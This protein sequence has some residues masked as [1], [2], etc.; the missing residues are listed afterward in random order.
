MHIQLFYVQLK[1]PLAS[2]FVRRPEP[3]TPAR[4]YKQP[5]PRS[6]IKL[7]FYFKLLPFQMPYIFI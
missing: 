3:E 1:P 6:S 7:H 4:G 2:N 5:G